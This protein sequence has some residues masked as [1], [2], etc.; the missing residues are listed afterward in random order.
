[1]YIVYFQ[2]ICSDVTPESRRRHTVRPYLT[3]DSKAQ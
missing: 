3:F 1:V 2:N